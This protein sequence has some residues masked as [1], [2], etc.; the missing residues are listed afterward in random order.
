MQILFSL[1]EAAMLIG[2]SLAALRKRVE[3][4][5]VS[6]IWIED[7]RGGAWYLTAEQISRLKGDSDII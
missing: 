1:H 5:A 6:A 7:S 2:T 4:G 3:R